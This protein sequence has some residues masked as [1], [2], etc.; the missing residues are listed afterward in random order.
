MPKWVLFLCNIFM[1]IYFFNRPHGEIANYFIQLAESLS[2][3]TDGEQQK[4]Q[5]R[6]CSALNL[7]K[8]Q[9]RS[10]H[11]P[12]D[13]TKT[14]RSITKLI[15]PDVSARVQML[16]SLMPNETLAAIRGKNMMNAFPKT[17]SHY[18][19]ICQTCSSSTTDASNYKLKLS[20]ID[21]ALFLLKKKFIKTYRNCV[22][23]SS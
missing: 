2:E 23:C 6:I 19:R 14:C 18:F 12:T 13:I 21:S 22:H 10:A 7:T 4:K 11:H 15:Y 16:T 3:N 5:K 17:I 20:I 8:R 9:L 1:L